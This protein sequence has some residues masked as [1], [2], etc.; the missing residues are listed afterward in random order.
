MKKLL[1]V[2]VIL[3]ITSCR[4]FNVSPVNGITTKNLT[5]KPVERDFIGTWEIDKYSYALINKMEYE[6]RKVELSLNS[7]G[8]FETTNLPN[9][10][11]VF[12]ENKN[13]DFINK[14]GTWKIGKDFED[15]N[16]ILFLNFE[17]SLKKEDAFGI[18]FELFMEE[19]KLILWHFVGD[20][21]SGERLLF[22]KK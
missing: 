17:N 16:W 3:S 6:N 9:F 4:Y 7:N 15:E 1:F 12:R 10:V 8:E 11:E 18:E 14:K 13:K 21:D 5:E 20:P 19:E 22:R 2:I